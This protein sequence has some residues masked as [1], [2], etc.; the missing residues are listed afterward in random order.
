MYWKA[1]NTKKMYIGWERYPVY[2][3][4]GLIRCYNCQEY[5]HKSNRCDN[6]AVCANC[7]EKHETKACNANDKKCVNCL[8]ANLR[9]KTKYNTQHAAVD[10]NCPSTK[11][12]IDILKSKI[13]Y[14]S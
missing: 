9:F 12:H 11:Y 14:G 13:D 4:I 10:P 5:N 3:D 6:E 2:E 7:A 8:N 1:I